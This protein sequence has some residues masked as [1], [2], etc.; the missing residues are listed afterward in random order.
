MSFAKNIGKNAG[1]GISKNLSCKYN[2]KLFDHANQSAT[3][4]FKNVSE[5]EIQKTSKTTGDWIGNKISD[6]I[7]NAS[8]MLPHNNSEPVT[9][10]E[11]ILRQK[12]VYFQKKNSKFLMI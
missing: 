7:T 3:D 11:E 8:E 5:R 6:K 4:A 10:E 2:Q 1:E 12:Y 9:N